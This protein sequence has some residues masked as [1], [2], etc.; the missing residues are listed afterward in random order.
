MPNVAGKKFPYTKEGMNAA[1]KAKQSLGMKHGGKVKV[2][3]MKHGG[4]AK[5]SRGGGAAISG[6]KYTGCK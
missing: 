2:K 3:K 1:S 4:E 6:T 5:N